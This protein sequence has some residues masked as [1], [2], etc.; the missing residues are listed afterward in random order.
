MSGGEIQRTILITILLI[1]SIITYIPNYTFGDES[2]IIYVDDDGGVDYTNIQDAINAAEAGDTI[3]VYNGTYYE[4]LNIQTQNI[5]LIGES[6]YNTIIDSSGSNQAIIVHNPSINISGFTIKNASISGIDITYSDHCIY[7]N[8]IISNSDYGIMLDQSN[9]NKIFDN[10]L[11]GNTMGIRINSAWNICKRNVIENCTIFNNSGE[12]IDLDGE[13]NIIKNCEIYSNF[14]GI[15]LSRVDDNIIE[16]CTFHNNTREGVDLYDCE[17]TILRDCKFWD[18]DDGVAFHY[19]NN[20]SVENSMFYRQ[21]HGT[22]HQETSNCTVM[23]C[24]FYDN[25]VGIYDSDNSNLTIQGCYL[26]GNIRGIKKY[27]SYNGEIKASDFVENQYG[28]YLSS[29][30]SSNNNIKNCTFSKNIDYGFYHYNAKYNSIVDCIF[31]NDAGFNLYGDTKN[32]IITNNII[33]CYDDNKLIYFLKNSQ[34]IS[35]PNDVGQVIIANCSNIDIHDLSIDKIHIFHSNYVNIKRCSSEII[36]KYCNHSI[37]NQCQIENTNYGIVIQKSNF[38]NITQ[39][40]IKNNSIGIYLISSMN[41]LI[42]N[43]YVNGDKNLSYY[44][45]NYGIAFYSS[46]NNSFNNN[47]I[48]DTVCG[49]NTSIM[50]QE[51]S[52]YNIFLEN[53]LFDNTKN[54]FDPCENNWDDGSKGNYWDDYSGIDTDGDG[55]GDTP[56]F[57]DGG[58]NKDSFPIMDNNH[59]LNTPPDIPVDPSP[60]NGEIFYDVTSINLNTDVSDPDNDT[61]DVGFYWN[62]LG[63]IND[64]GI[65]ADNSDIDTISQY[66]DGSLE[67]V[68]NW[69]IFR[70][71]LDGDSDVDQDDIDLMQNANDNSIVFPGSYIGSDYNVESGETAELSVDDLNINTNYSW[72]ALADDGKNTSISNIFHFA[73][74]SKN[75]IEEN[76]EIT[77][78][79]SIKEN[80]NFLITV[81]VNDLS[82]ANVRIK[83]AGNTYFTNSNGIV[84]LQAPSVQ[85]NS[86]YIIQAEKTGF[87]LDFVSIEVINS[88]SPIIDLL[89]PKSGETCSDFYNI[90]WNTK[91][92]SNND[93][94][95]SILY[96]YDTNNWVTIAD[97]LDYNANI[98]KWDT[99]KIPN[100]YP[101]KIKI[102]LIEDVNSDGIYDKIVSTD[103]SDD[104]FEIDNSLNK[105]GWIT[106][107]V[108][109]KENG[110]IKPLENARVV[111]V[112]SDDGIVVTSKS[113]LTNETGNYKI[114]VNKG[115]YTIKVCK[116]NYITKTKVNQTIWL[117]YETICNF[118]LNKGNVQDS[119]Y[120]FLYN[121]HRGLIDK[122]IKE[123][124]VGGEL[125]IQY[126][127]N[128]SELE[129]HIFFYDNINITFLKVDQSNISLTVDGNE[130]SNGKTIVVN[131][132]KNFFSNDKIYLIYDGQPIRLAENISDV[133]NPNDDGSNPEYIITYGANG[134]QVLI[135][136]PHFSQHEINLLS[137]ESKNLINKAEDLFSKLVYYILTLVVFL[138]IYLG[139]VLYI[140][141]K[142]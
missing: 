45:N 133:L 119:N 67:N 31:T 48:T 42:E 113:T 29:E 3:F 126:K 36:F 52:N 134:T 26:E 82:I 32:E 46:I 95:V 76:L 43:N 23:N 4:S 111:L 69:Q 99:K 117:N 59:Y 55:I 139:P 142:K 92:T 18:N 27:D 72:Y 114:G 21:S 1:L 61:L 38:N 78:P 10:V 14:I 79:N 89:A 74:K 15:E 91:N 140:Q 77:A 22:D 40:E 108:G 123:K 62:M 6:K 56:Y 53:R 87:N 19:G 85:Q 58:E 109:E 33:S 125:S 41:N 30:N 105:I 129:K 20:N 84:Y 135:S 93:L 80:E 34:D 25:Y 128:L 102:N 5:N 54:A 132:D 65:I 66:V 96:K 137:Q 73:I 35:V 70:M 83:F 136:I 68:T 16:G 86:Y 17:N 90:V 141:K 120:P 57:I 64:N 103:I 8:I 37:V 11:S 12:G 131:I 88:V 104:F 106:G 94:I 97:N 100:G 124:N 63:D 101:Y 110:E 39:N 118:T 50:Y 116:Q 81:K 98:Y 75:I 49:I 121:E 7:D 2:D 9:D 138:F 122:G 47:T 28:I 130:T 71:D 44:G 24:D 107:F 60:Y 112:I 13:E 127:D 115:S 51:E